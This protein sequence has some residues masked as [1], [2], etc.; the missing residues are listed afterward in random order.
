MISEKSGSE[1]KLRVD[2]V[3][4]CGGAKEGLTGLQYEVK[5]RGPRLPQLYFE[6]GVPREYFY[7]I[8]PQGEGRYLVGT[9]GRGSI[10]RKLDAFMGSHA[11][12]ERVEVASVV[13]AFGGLVIIRPPSSPYSSRFQG[14]LAAGDAAN[15]VKITTGGGLAFAAASASALA[16]AVDRE[17]IWRYESW[18]RHRKNLIRA[19]AFLRQIY[20]WLP[21]S[22]MESAFNGKMQDYLAGHPLL[23][24]QHWKYF[25][26]NAPDLL[27]ALIPRARVK[28][29]GR[30]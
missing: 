26:E 13:R 9:A 21:S 12:R 28:K 23:F 22:A 10:K 18:F 25:V 16:E 1:E 29:S 11:L 27:A 8:V 4:D 20:R 5:G 30:I 14:A 15:Q 7:W 17:E 19:H 24:D 3:V 6:R 2:A